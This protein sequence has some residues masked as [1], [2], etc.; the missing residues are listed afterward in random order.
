MKKNIG[1]YFLRKKGKINHNDKNH[2]IHCANTVQ[3]L[4]ESYNILLRRGNRKR[5]KGKRSFEYSLAVDERIM[6]IIDSKYNKEEK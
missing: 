4:L 1:V 2:L 3:K 5:N 6:K